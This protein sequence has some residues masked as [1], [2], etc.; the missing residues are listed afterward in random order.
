M[1]T[2]LECAAGILAALFQRERTGRGD[3]IDVSMAQTMLYV[4]EH[5]HDHLWDGPGR[6]VVDPQ[7][8]ARRLPGADR[9]QRRDGRSSAATRPS[10]APSTVLLQPSVVPT[11]APIRGSSTSPARLA[12]LD[13]LFAAAA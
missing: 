12:H 8:R 7:L 5:V 6:P 13:E 1:Y 9:G 3:R 11:W 4:N 2:A 10:A